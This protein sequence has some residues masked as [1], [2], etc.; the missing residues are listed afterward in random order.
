MERSRER[1]ELM[2]H[3]KSI[4][5]DFTFFDA[6]DGKKLIIPELSVKIKDAFR[7]GILGCALSHLG[8]MQ[9]ALA[10][11]EDIIFVM[12]DDIVLCDDFWERINYIEGLKLS[13]DMFLLGGFF[14]KDATTQTKYNHIFSVQQ[15]NGT[16]GYIITKKAMEFYVRNVNY[17]WGSDQFFSDIM[18]KRFKCYA[19]LPMLIGVRDC[20]SEI[21]QSPVNYDK[22]TYYRQEIIKNIN[23]PYMS[24]IDK[25]KIDRKKEM[26]K[27]DEAREKWLKENP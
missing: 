19:F 17:N 7:H 8:V 14:D 11:K 26:T 9:M 1:R 3:K 16:Y 18:Y 10:N 21:V 24:Y 5:G 27:N 13:F 15:M 4:I 22:K 20:F 12:E 23:D 2:M 6:V 25:N